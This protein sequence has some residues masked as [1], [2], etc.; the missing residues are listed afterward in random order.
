MFKTFSALALCFLGFGL[1][2]VAECVGQNLIAAMP[3]SESA[4]LRQRSH[5]VP[6]AQGNFWRA[7]KGAQEITLIGTYH[8]EDAR[9][10]ETLARIA[11]A[12]AAAKTLL[13]EAG[14]AEMAALKEK[15]GQEPDLMVITDGPTLPEQ[16]SPDLWDK[17][18]AAMRQRGVPSF[19]A[20]KMQPW[21]L[22]ML[23]SVPP[24]AMTDMGEDHGLDARLIETAQT[25][26]VPVVALEPFDTI[27]DIFDSMSREDQLSMITST[28]AVESLSE[29][30]TVTMADSYFAEESRMIWELS[31]D[32]TLRQE[33]YSPER[34]A[35][36]FAVMEEAMMTR[37]NRNWIAVLTGA[38]E[39]G[40]VL[41]AF[42]ALHLSGEDGVLALLG[43]EG[44]TVERLAFR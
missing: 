36:E 29:D 22:S 15:L 31:R 28:L 19:I 30:M 24:C 41:A 26:G 44:F 11:P 40:P 32:L 7:T 13:V 1:P 17:L 38:A 39:K 18:A 35:R 21:Y 2:A 8:M 43:A 34:V 5:A 12:L 10:A 14:P 42:G 27:F 9:H 20:A 33:G 23:L 16:L 3:E 6:F 4:D 25:Q 37:R